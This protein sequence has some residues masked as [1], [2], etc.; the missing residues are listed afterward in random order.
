MR[1]L[2]LSVVFHNDLSTFSFLRDQNCVSSHITHTFDKVER[3]CFGL[4]NGVTLV[5]TEQDGILFVL[6][7]SGSPIER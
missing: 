5:A 2:N 6:S 1:G 3:R 7:T 4:N